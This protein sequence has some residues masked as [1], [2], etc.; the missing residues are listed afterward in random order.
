MQID[1]LVKTM[2]DINFGDCGTWGSNGTPL[3]EEE[4]AQLSIEEKQ[5][6][7]YKYVLE[8]KKMLSKLLL[9]CTIKNEQEYKE[10]LNKVSE[11]MDKDDNESKEFEELV[12]QIEIYEDINIDMI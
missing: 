8:E 7:I 4:I 9:P 11:L 6:F 5:D 3:I 12:K 10:A 1:E 2:I